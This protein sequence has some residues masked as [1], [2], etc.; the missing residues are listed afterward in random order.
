M[1]VRNKTVQNHFH[2]IMQFRECIEVVEHKGGLRGSV[3]PSGYNGHF[4]ELYLHFASC[5]STY[6]TCEGSKYG[7]KGQMDQGTYGNY[8][9]AG[10][11]TEYLFGGRLERM[12]LKKV[13]EIR[14]TDTASY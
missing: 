6:T 11:V 1:C 4:E 3:I 14:L 10:C 8:I 13:S 5:I 7:F 2:F 9:Q 12:L